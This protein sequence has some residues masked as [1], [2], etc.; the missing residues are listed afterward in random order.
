MDDLPTNGLGFTI[1]PDLELSTPVTLTVEYTDDDILG[2]DESSLVLYNYDWATQLWT[3][4]DPCGVYVR[5]PEE[6]TLK[7]VVCHFSDYAMMNLLKWIHLPM[8]IR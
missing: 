6:N 7:A 5:L 1:V 2:M 4:A 3:D 8:I